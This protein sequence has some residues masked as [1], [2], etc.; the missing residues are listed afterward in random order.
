MAPEIRQNLQES[1]LAPLVLME[2]CLLS[3]RFSAANA[4]GSRIAGIIELAYIAGLSLDSR[5]PAC[6]PYTALLF[7]DPNS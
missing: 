2:A 5:F 3:C 4:Y 1:K 7:G 6:C